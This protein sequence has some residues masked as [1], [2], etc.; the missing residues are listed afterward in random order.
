MDNTREIL[1]A[2]VLLINTDGFLNQL[3]DAKFEQILNILKHPAFGET[4]TKID[5]L[6]AQLATAGMPKELEPTEDEAVE[7]N[8]EEQKEEAKEEAKEEVKEVEVKVEEKQAN[9]K[10]FTSIDEL[11]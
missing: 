11:D 4:A 10:P 3:Y 2:L 9:G 1:D 7:E 8:E 5:V 6:S